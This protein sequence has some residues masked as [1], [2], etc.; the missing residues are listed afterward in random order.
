MSEIHVVAV[1]QN[2]PQ[3]IAH[4]TVSRGEQILHEHCR[5]FQDK[6]NCYLE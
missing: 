6:P 5:E 2:R 1:A 4:I 3:Q